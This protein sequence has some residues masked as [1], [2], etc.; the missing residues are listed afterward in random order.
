MSRNEIFS[1]YLC[2]LP[3]VILYSEGDR[4]KSELNL[5][6]IHDYDD[7]K[8]SATIHQL[9]SMDIFGLKESD[10]EYEFERKLNVMSKQINKKLKYYWD[11]KNIQIY[12]RRGK[13]DNILVSFTDE[14]MEIPPELGI[15]SRGLKQFLH[16]F[17]LNIIS[18]YKN[19]TL[20]F[21]DPPVYLHAKWQFDLLNILKNLSI[22]N[23]IVISTHSPFLIDIYKI[24]KT[25]SIIKTNE[26]TMLANNIKNDFDIYHPIRATMGI[27]LDHSFAFAPPTVLV[28]GDIDKILLKAFFKF[29]EKDLKKSHFNAL[30]CGGV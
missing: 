15:R 10:K 11:E 12:L 7:Y 22:N 23:Q 8:E 18:G 1:D 25:R 4:L 27:L 21:D 13:E 5:G 24:S 26:G 16:I 29:Y 9:S 30:P 28:E 19:K 6:D 17:V 14:N 2:L 3:E 20:L